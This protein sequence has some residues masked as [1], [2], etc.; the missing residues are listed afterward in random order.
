MP[1][2]SPVTTPDAAAG[3]RRSPQLNK[4]FG[5]GVSTLV[6]QKTMYVGNPVVPYSANQMQQTIYTTDGQVTY[7][8]QL[9]IC[10]ATIA[11][12]VLTLPQAASCYGRK[13][14]AVKMDSSV[15]TVTF[16]VDSP[17]AIWK[18]STWT[19]L[20]KQYETVTWLACMDASNNYGWLALLDKAV[21]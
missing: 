12:F 6:P 1:I 11:S 21:V 20:T 2:I 19:G 5:P 3:A 16:T 7:A 18:Y 13:V 14:I 10:D 8:D 9:A 4:V 17:S 15:N